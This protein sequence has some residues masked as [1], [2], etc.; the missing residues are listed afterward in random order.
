MDRSSVVMVVLLAVIVATVPTPVAAA[1]DPRFETTVPA[2]R[3][4]PGAE[5]SVTIQLV[6]DAADPD[7][8]T[9]TASNVVVEAVG[10][11]TPFEVIS[12][13]R[14][15]G[16][17]ADGRTVPVS[18]RLSVPNDAPAGLYAL[19]LRVTYEYDG[20]ERETT[21]VV[22][23]LRVPERPIIE[24][25]DVGSSVVLREHGTVTLTLVNNGS[26]TAHDAVV[27]VESQSAALSLEGSSTVAQSVGNWGENET[28][29]F[30]VSVGSTPSATVREYA[31]TVIPTYED[32][33]GVPQ[34][35]TARTVGVTPL[36][37]QTFD[38]QSVTIDTHGKTVATLQATLINTGERTVEDARVTL[39]SDSPGVSV[40]EPT[41]P[42]GALD[43][44]EETDVA[45]ELRVA[46]DAVPGV[47]QFSAAVTYDRGGGH[48]YHSDSIA[49]QT[50][51]GTGT[52]AI[53]LEPVNATFA[54][55][56]TN[57]FVVRVTNT[58]DERLS[59]LHARLLVEPPYE[60]A[61]STSYVD[62]L[63]PG[64]SATLTFEVTTPADAVATKDAFPIVVNAT[65]PNE[66]S[67]TAGPI[68]V[69]FA[70]TTGGGPA[71]STTSIVIGAVAVVV[72]LGAG[73]WWLH[74]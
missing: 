69:P 63:A 46:P 10:E 9:T 60:S 17:M 2:P 7:E 37:R 29:T 40:T 71:D 64:D 41:A 35:A 16:T 28:R 44:G 58:G 65:A 45:F 57:R 4:T 50:A 49:V 34:R 47:R 72:V 3:L 42:V 68:L 20:D 8:R 26:A 6:N 21:T 30:T 66:R 48:E 33:V 59:E 11:G 53:A 1:E 73:W 74:R 54:V 38:L 13:P 55:D 24:V 18:V 27:T 52:G 32:E 61:V 56:D 12:G 15:L 62:S 23:R 36:P 67:V 51:I 22:A 5:Q 31:L 70:I 19:P 43:P 14:R 25:A 39:E